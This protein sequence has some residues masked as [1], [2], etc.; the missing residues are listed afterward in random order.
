[1]ENGDS[2]FG[3]EPVTDDHHDLMLV[4]VAYALP[5]S[6]KIIPLNV[7]KS[8]TVR[9]AILASGILNDFPE[10]DLD[11]S[12]VGIFSKKAKLDQLLQE[13]DR[14]EIYR[15][16]LADPKEVRRRRAAEGKVMRKGG[17]DKV[18]AK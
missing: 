9:D 16:L 5:D 12:S 7:A 14:V 3:D 15:P 1:M 13:K 6:Q 4:E 8:T 18:S 11:S 2:A 10:I 17:G